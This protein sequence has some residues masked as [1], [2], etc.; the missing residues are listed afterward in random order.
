MELTEKQRS[1]LT[2]AI[3]Y[4]YKRIAVNLRI[5]EV[6]VR[7]RITRAI[8]AL[9]AKDPCHAIAKAVQLEEIEAPT[10]LSKLQV[11]AIERELQELGLE[12]VALAIKTD[13][14]DGEADLYYQKLMTLIAALRE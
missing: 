4:Y 1:V 14:G 12:H 9:G 11:A 5:T 3:G 7:G 2:L 6:A 13:M 10:K 8:R